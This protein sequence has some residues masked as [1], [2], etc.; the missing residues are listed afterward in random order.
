[1]KG[2][3]PIFFQNDRKGCTLNNLDGLGHFLF[4]LGATGKKSRR[5]VVTTPPPLGGLGLKEYA[6]FL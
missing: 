1:M 3:T 6:K 5:R 2:V 4:G